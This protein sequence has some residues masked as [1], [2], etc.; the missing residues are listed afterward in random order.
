MFAFRFI[1]MCVCLLLNVYI[2]WVFAFNWCTSCVCVRFY[3]YARHVR[4]FAFKFMHVM[5]VCSL[6]N[7]ARHVCVFAFRF[8]HAMCVCVFIFRCMYT[9][10]LA[11]NWYTSIVWSLL[12]W[13]TSCECVHLY[14][15]YIVVF[16]LNIFVCSLLIN[17]H[18][19]GVSGLYTCIVCSS[20]CFRCPYNVY[21]CIKYVWAFNLF[22]HS[23]M[24]F[25]SYMFIGTLII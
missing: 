19:V 6:L 20:V 5:C 11:F 24:Y 12:D 22:I 4:V 1:H 23:I 15:S 13:Y 18:Y 2:S 21:V 17:V 9:C 16:T 8:M 25:T 10:V 3:I 7:Y 14:A